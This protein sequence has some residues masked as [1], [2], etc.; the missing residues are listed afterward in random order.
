MLEL[1]VAAHEVTAPSAGGGSAGGG[2]AG[3]VGATSLP[4]SYTTTAVSGSSSSELDA[5]L[6]SSPFVVP[7]WERFAATVSGVAAD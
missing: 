6:E 1:G 5:S 4:G 7:S 3:G 2:A